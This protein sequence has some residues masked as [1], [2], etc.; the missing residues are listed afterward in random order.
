M[1]RL[2]VLGELEENKNFEESKMKEVS[3]RLVWNKQEIF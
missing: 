3:Y 2:I 1:N